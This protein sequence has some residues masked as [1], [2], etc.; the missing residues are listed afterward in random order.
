M[1]GR[2][3]ILLETT[4][5]IVCIHRLY[6]RKLKPDMAVCVL[7][8]CCVILS[9]LGNVWKLGGYCTAASYFLVMLYCVRKCGDSIPGACFSM[10]FMMALLAILQ[11]SFM[12]A[13]DFLLGISERGRALLTNVLVLGSCVAVLPKVKIYRLRTY[14]R[15]WNG[16]LLFSAAFLVCMIVFM[17]FQ[18]RRSG[19]IQLLLFLFAV[20]MAAMLLLFMGKYLKAQDE[21]SEAEKELEVT[22]G[23]QER[24]DELVKAVR[25]RQHGFKNHLAAILATHYTCKS[26][27][28]LVRAQEKYCGSLVEEN[29]Y[30]DLLA[31]GN[32]V[33]AGF[34]YEKFREM[35]EQGVE[36]KFTVRGSQGECG[37]PIH[38]LV[39]MTGILLDNAY[40]AVSGREND[41][42]VYFRFWEEEGDYCLAVANPFHYVSYGEIE[43]WFQMGKSA[44]GKERGLGLYRVRCLCEEWGCGIL[45]GGAGTAGESRIEFV[46][47]A[48]KADSV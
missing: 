43:S 18:Q 5:V 10:F 13:F 45:Y 24:Y 34:L 3:S 41:R 8:M 14:V 21:K 39:E 33:M 47:K 6:N 17:Q 42:T 19:Y 2:I 31:L 1:T 26:Y 20:P 38:L 16:F 32:A 25:L 44:K 15:K 12:V 40:Q 30:N 11:F 35:E 29:R 28:K 46:I 4:A 23:M 7:Y 22:R 9:E 36:V 37:V 48:G 27:E